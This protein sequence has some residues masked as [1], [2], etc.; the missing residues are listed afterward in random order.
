MPSN[1]SPRTGGRWRALDGDWMCGPNGHTIVRGTN[2]EQARLS[3]TT[4]SSAQEGRSLDGCLGSPRGEF[5][6][7]G[8]PCGAPPEWRGR[9]L[10]RQ[11]GPG[12]PAATRSW[13]PTTR[14]VREPPTVPETDVF[15]SGLTPLWDG[16]ILVVG[17][18]KLYPTDTNPFIGSK[19]AY[20]L[21]PE[22]G[23]T[24]LA[25]MVFG[26]CIRQRSCSR[27]FESSSFRGQ[28]TTA[29]SHPE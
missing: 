19:G 16:K 9:L 27:M 10:L 3:E 21:E 4:R 24:R 13:N 25:D 11:H 8:S 1:R 15:C 7:R 14:E 26:R 22:V 12:T 5:T 29:A 2:T 18:T 20:V 28:A 6:G 23:W 17:G